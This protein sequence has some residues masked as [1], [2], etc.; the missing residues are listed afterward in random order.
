MSYI[1]IKE[2]QKMNN[3][4]YLLE[5]IENK[6]SMKKSIEE[7]FVLL[8]K[9]EVEEKCITKVEDAIKMVELN[10]YYEGIL[11]GAKLFRILN[12]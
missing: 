8:T 1:E 2:K 7:L 12:K 4:F 6:E 5:S 9:L 11:D 10:S 3:L